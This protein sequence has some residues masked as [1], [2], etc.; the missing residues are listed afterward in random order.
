MQALK[1]IGL[2][3][4]SFFLFISLI[5]FSAAFMVNGTALNPK[6][7]TKELDSIDVSSIA[8]QAMEEEFEDNPDFPEELKTALND[9][10]EE[11]EP[12]IK[13]AINEAILSVGDYIRGKTD[14]L[15]LAQVLSDTFL[16][17][18]FLADLLDKVDMPAVVEA[19]ID[20]EEIDEELL[21]SLIDTV[22]EIEPELK[23]QAAAASDPIF[24][25]L[26]AETN[27]LDL[28]DTLRSTLLSTDFTTTLI[29]NLDIVPIASEFLEDSISGVIPEDMD[30]L[31]DELDDTIATLE[32]SIKQA[33]SDTDQILDYLLGE[34]QSLSIIISLEP[35]RDDLETILRQVFL[36]NIPSAW[37]DWPQAEIDN[38]LEEFLADAIPETFEFDEE[39]FGSELP[40][41][42]ADGLAE[43]E[44]AL[45]EARD[46]INDALS[47]VENAPELE[48][49]KRYIGWGITGYWGLIALIVVLIL[50]II[51]IYRQVKGASLHLGIM[52]LIV[53]TIE[54]VA[55]FVGR[56][57]AIREIDIGDIPAAA[58]DL[59][60]RFITA[61]TGPLAALSIGLIVVG[62]ILIAASIIYPRLR[63]SEA[64]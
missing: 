28:V 49:V 29:D 54:C 26:L 8:S 53:G 44:G 32:P 62:V 34:R 6:F 25:Y 57:I 15:D 50:G 31:I 12:V 45:T 1:T 20:T 16:N 23:E 41:Q 33:L 21:T 51:G 4:I 3:I 14:E 42:I 52:F 30:F 9:T 59:P 22:A 60:D 46:D 37:E 40:E 17:S 35:V 18:E 36:D 56:G 10:I 43:A 64:D 63:P 58:Q 5:V 27:D 38:Q 19:S 11:A 24:K 7:I 55:V 47:E 61:V 2:F 13:A 48:D 39:L